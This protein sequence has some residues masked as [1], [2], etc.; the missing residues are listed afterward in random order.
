VVAV[1]VQQL[2]LQRKKKSQRRKKN[3]KKWTLAEVF[4]V[5]MTNIELNDC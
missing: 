3:L 1:V 4:S 2:L 5:M